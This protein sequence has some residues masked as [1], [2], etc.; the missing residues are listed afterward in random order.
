[1][2]AAAH[3]L[4][5]RHV[6]RDVV[7]GS[8]P[9]SE[10]WPRYGIVGLDTIASPSS[11]AA[12]AGIR[13]EVLHRTP[14]TGAVQPT[15]SAATS[16]S[17]TS[18]RRGSEYVAIETSAPSARPTRSQSTAASD[19]VTAAF[20]PRSSPISS[21]AGCAGGCAENS[22][23]A[24]RLLRRSERAAAVAA[25]DHHSS[26]RRQQRSGR[27]R[28]GERAEG[29]R[30]T[31]RAPRACVRRCP[32]ARVA[33]RSRR[34]RS[35]APAGRGLAAPGRAT[36]R[37]GGRR[38][39]RL[40]VAAGAGTRARAGAPRKRNTSD[41]EGRRDARTSEPG[42]QHRRALPAPSR[43]S[44]FVRFEPG[45]SSDAEF[46]MKTEPYRNGRSSMPRRRAACTSTGVMKTTEVSRLSTAVTPATSA[47]IATRSARGG[48]RLEASRAP[49]ASKSP[50]AA[51][52]EPIRSS[53]A[54]ST[55]GG[56]AC[57]GGGYDL[58]PKQN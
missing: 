42:A 48:S 44:R 29:R 15:A 32:D 7:S 13:R 6:D 4:E 57:A 24:G 30:R 54:T 39:H 9:W 10:P 28:A 8:R 17:G 27:R 31:R 45:R 22:T 47:S 58:I 53:P 20:G 11:G 3:A 38:A 18:A 26:R 34:G 12:G 49:T 41:D 37:H 21:A 16:V 50:S 46:A 40:R 1:M 36:A 14:R 5:Q 52:T 2:R 23:A 51:A 33:T 35:R 55:N 25:V 56:Q 19:P 43:T